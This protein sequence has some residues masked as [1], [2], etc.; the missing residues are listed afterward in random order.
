M[1]KKSRVWNSFLTSYHS[2]DILVY[3]CI[4]VSILLSMYYYA[5][6]SNHI[7]RY[8]LDSKVPVSDSTNFLE[9]ISVFLVEFSYRKSMDL[10]KDFFKIACIRR[11]QILPRI[12]VH[13]RRRWVHHPAVIKLFFLKCR[14]NYQVALMI[15]FSL[16]E[17]YFE[18][19]CMSKK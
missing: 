1:S 15:R 16:I 7:S 14:R 17:F 13:V 4:T 9:I 8:E 10:R 2:I 19:Y 5:S 18:I 12:P 11:T 3:R 6:Y